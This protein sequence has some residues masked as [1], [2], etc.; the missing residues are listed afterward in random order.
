MTIMKTVD[1]DVHALDAVLHLSVSALRS[2]RNG[3]IVYVFRFIPKL[4]VR[5]FQWRLKLYVSIENAIFSSICFYN[6]VFRDEQTFV[7]LK[8]NI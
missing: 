3:I 1:D 6:E 4:F 8:T 7:V 2:R 5:M